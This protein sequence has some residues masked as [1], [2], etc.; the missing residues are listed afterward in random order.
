[1]NINMSD[2]SPKLRN[3]CALRFLT[4]S[5]LG[6]SWQHFECIS[7]ECSCQDL[8]SDEEVENRNAVINPSFCFTRLAS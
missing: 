2:E 1:M 5:F 8:L 7:L 3:R 4:S 6:K